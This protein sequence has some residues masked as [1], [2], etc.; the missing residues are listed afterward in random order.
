MEYENSG[1]VI[2]PNERYGSRYVDI[3]VQC[4]QFIGRRWEVLK[5]YPNA[6]VAYRTLANQLSHKK[7]SAADAR[8]QIGRLYQLN[9]QFEQAIEAYQDLFDNNPESIWRNE[10]VYQQAVCYRG[11]REFAKAYDAFKAYMSLGRDV[12]YYRKRNRLSANSR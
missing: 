6:I 10:G 4:F 9:G 5:N 3:V 11:I 8:Y 2:L 7:F 1:R 12:S